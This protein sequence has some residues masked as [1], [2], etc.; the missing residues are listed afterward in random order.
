[1]TSKMI[2]LNIVWRYQITCDK[3]GE[4]EVLELEP[5]ANEE[6]DSQTEKMEWDGFHEC[7]GE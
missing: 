5:D 4:V 6:V 7:E 1:M 3:C 2:L